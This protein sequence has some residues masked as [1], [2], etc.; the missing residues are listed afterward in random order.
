MESAEHFRRLER[1]YAS[2]PI[3]RFYN[4]TYIKIAEESIEITLQVEKKYWHAAHGMH[5]SVYFRLLDDAAYLAA[6]SV[7]RDFF[8][9]TST[10][11]ID[12]HK[13]VKTGKV[14]AVGT[15]QKKLK[16]GYTAKAVLYNEAGE[17][18]ASGSGTFVRSKKP[19]ARALGYSS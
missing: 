8:L 14:T 7:E 9:L 11:S 15:V 10:F 13:P 2:A 19:L 4:T 5:G 6:A 3:Q 12:F 1:M 16:N 17:E 18:L